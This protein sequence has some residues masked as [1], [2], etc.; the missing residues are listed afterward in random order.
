MG[1]GVNT[2]ETQWF[3]VG[4]WY[5][6]RHQPYALVPLLRP[7]YVLCRYMDPFENLTNSLHAPTMDADAKTGQAD[8]GVHP[9]F[10]S[11][12]SDAASQPLHK[13]ERSSAGFRSVAIT[14]VIDC[15]TCFGS[16]CSWMAPPTSWCTLY[17][18]HSCDHGHGVAVAA[19]FFV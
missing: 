1:V 8:S 7:M 12:R 16:E 6:H 4:S 18:C 11:C 2:F 14:V 17:C 9:R 15:Y 5:V 3:H 13:V 10:C 19:V